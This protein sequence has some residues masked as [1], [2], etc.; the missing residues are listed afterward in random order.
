[1]E[2]FSGVPPSLG[3][4]E[5]SYPSECVHQLV[6]LQAR[7]NPAAPALRFGTEQI[8]YSELEARSN[9]LA[10]LLQQRGA[11]PGT[12]VALL[13][14]R[15]PAMVIA[16]L[17]ILKTGAAYLPL[18]ATY[19]SARL[20]N[21]IVDSGASLLLA[22]S[23][24]LARVSL[25]PHPNTLV[26]DTCLYSAD[27]AVDPE[28][29]D[30]KTG[31]DLGVPVTHDDTCYV[32]FTSGSTGQPKGVQIRHGSLVNLLWSLKDQ[33]GV[34]ADDVLLGTAS[35]SFD[36]CTFE[37]LLPLI[38]GACIAL[39]TSDE[40]ADPSRLM[41]T[42]KDSGA[43]ILATTPVTW[44]LLI[45]A[46]WTGN[47]SIK[48]ICGGE[49]MTQGLARDLLA[50]SPSV[51]NLYG[52][53]ETAICS[54]LT[55]V[56]SAESAIPLGAPVAN[57]I[58]YVLDENRQPV[59]PGSFGELYI[60]GAGLAAGYWNRPDLTA[61]RFLFIQT[62]QDGEVRVYKTGDRVRLLADGGLVFAGRVDFQVKLRGFRIELGEIE[63]AARA[64]PGVGD[65]VVIKIDDADRGDFLAA[66]AV[67]AGR[68]STAPTQLSAQ[69]RAHLARALPSYMLP[70]SIR[71][72]DS[73]PVT[74]NAKVDR[75]QLA[76]LVAEEP[77]SMEPGELPTGPVELAI[78]TLWRQF[79]RRKQIGRHD[80][81]FEVGGDSLSAAQLAAVRSVWAAVRGRLTLSVAD[82]CPLRFVP[83]RTPRF[84]LR[85]A[86]PG[87]P[88]TGRKHL[89][90]D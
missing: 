45:Q 21:M 34:A 19:S 64:C 56:R 38:T 8:R 20:A 42:L 31:G 1:M 88:S 78:E 73:F 9:R 79:L 77:T 53:T 59:A 51:W 74:P 76:L 17:A 37:L 29:P 47:T 84:P 89:L 32:I 52:P 87:L 83:G 26:L 28:T 44:H 50:R 60:G 36:V 49:E 6:S 80:N 75:R 63:Q 22:E 85:C 2:Q 24:V 10:R 14:D 66:F 81:F 27:D 90:L 7:Q 68:E 35:L 67:P 40:I 48:V 11:A 18:D 58:L 23:A 55:R 57:T 3:S 69:I 82:H 86:E 62:A 54:T 71:V 41:A 61:E 5:S 4:L 43:T 30:P 33:P 15:S 25:S 65:A 46:G 13:A 39:A 16:L 12:L 72:L 70:E